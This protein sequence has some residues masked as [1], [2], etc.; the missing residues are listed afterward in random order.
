M[1]TTGHWLERAPQMLNDEG[2]CGSGEP[3]E[4]TLDRR[5]LWRLESFL[6]V[7]GTNPTQRQMGQDLRQY[8]NESCAHHWHS[9]AADADIAAHRQCQYC[10]DVEWGD[11]PPSHPDTETDDERA[12]WIADDAAQVR[13]EDRP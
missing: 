1:T 10:Y 9:Y 11:L 13:R 8:L 7:Y 3:D 4:T 12:A 2:R 5:W 6:A